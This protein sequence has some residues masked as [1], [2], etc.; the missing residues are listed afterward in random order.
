MTKRTIRRFTLR[1]TEEQYR[2]IT[3]RAREWQSAGSGSRSLNDWILTQLLS[4]QTID[5][6]LDMTSLNEVHRRW[7][8]VKESR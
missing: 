1:M 3:A 5:S 7:R 4:E 8:A 6:W 2:T